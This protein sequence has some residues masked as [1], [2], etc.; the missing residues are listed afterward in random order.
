MKTLLTILTI[1]L[2]SA[3]ANA[4]PVPAPYDLAAVDAATNWAAYFLIAGIL[5][6]CVLEARQAYRDAQRRRHTAASS[7]AERQGV[8]LH[9]GTGSLP[10]PHAA[11]S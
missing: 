6:Y 4:A 2:L 3:P 5:G 11:H 8:P 9:P 10:L 1:G 7:R